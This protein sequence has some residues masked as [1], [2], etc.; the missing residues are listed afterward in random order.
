MQSTYIIHAVDAAPALDANDPAWRLAN[1]A[2]IAHFRPESSDHH[3]RT[4]A[5]LLHDKTGIYGL[6]QV[7]D[8]YVKAIRAH[9]QG[10][11]WK[12]SCVEFFVQPKKECGYFNFE[13]NCGGSLL[14]SY[15]TDPT[16]TPTGLKKAQPLPEEIGEQVKTRSTLSKVVDPE[17]ATPCEWKLA[18][19]IPFAV[20]E[21]YIGKL[22]PAAGDQWHGNFYKCAEDISHPHWGAW[23][24]VDQLNF[25]LPRCFGTLIFH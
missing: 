6:F 7:N 20:M 16:R 18:F 24:P 14:C 5:R 1:I 12:D 19:Y 17:I 13:M 4:L 21:P 25:H 3:P 23:A 22:S 15:V 11:V 10:E 8:K 2:E 9:F